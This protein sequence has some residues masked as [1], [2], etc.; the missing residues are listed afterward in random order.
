M[1]E[2]ERD[3]LLIAIFTTLTIFLWVFFELLQ[4]T[5]TSTVSQPLQKAV[6]PLSSKIDTSVLDVLETKQTFD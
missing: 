3:L 2:N 1:I 4:T 5:K 6:L